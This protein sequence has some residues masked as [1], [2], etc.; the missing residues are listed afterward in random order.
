[1]DLLTEHFRDVSDRLGA[2]FRPSEGMVRL[3]AQVALTQ[4]TAKAVAFGEIRVGLY[5]ESFRAYE[6][7]GD[8]WA[9]K[10]EVD[11]ARSYYEQAL[12]RTTDGAPIREKLDK[13]GG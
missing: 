4:D 8:V 9:A 5:P 11:K 10:Q 1:P 7:L 12:A 6:F 3:M 2:T 13:L